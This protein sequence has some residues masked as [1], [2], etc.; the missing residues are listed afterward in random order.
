MIRSEHVSQFAL[1]NSVSSRLEKI[2]I[3]WYNERILV[4]E[5]THIPLEDQAK[6]L[7]QTAKKLTE[8]LEAEALEVDQGQLRR[9]EDQ[10]D[11]PSPT[12]P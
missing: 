5:N 7:S 3:V 6:L 11:A 9:L 8:N 1:R 4:M 12:C 10:F 2:T